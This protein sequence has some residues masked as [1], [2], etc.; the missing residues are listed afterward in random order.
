[1]KDLIT[2]INEK[3]LIN[4]NY[5]AVSTNDEFYEFAKS[6]MNDI[7]SRKAWKQADNINQIRKIITSSS[8]RESIDEKINNIIR[9]DDYIFYFVC[10]SAYRRNQW[11]SMLDWIN[12]HEN[13]M[14]FLANDT[15]G[16]GTYEVRVFETSECV[17]GLFGNIV[18]TN[19]NDGCR[20]ILYAYK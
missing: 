7:S 20:I 17:I 5:N 18:S 1:M 10:K 14:V 12:E 11:K 19:P 13:D 3:L 16:N 15:F 2:F 8:Y 4:K 9:E 6:I